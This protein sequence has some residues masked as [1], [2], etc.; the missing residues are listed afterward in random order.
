MINEV[1]ITFSGMAPLYQYC[2]DIKLPLSGSYDRDQH[3]CHVQTAESSLMLYYIVI[4]FAVHLPP[5][6]WRLVFYIRIIMM[7]YKS[8]IVFTS[9]PKWRTLPFKRFKVKYEV[10]KLEKLCNKLI[11]LTELKTSLN[12]LQHHYT[13]VFSW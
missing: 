10:Q 1:H 2:E 8:H 5:Q 3:S 7:Y 9:P 4:C 11:Y 12:F 13:I 6:D